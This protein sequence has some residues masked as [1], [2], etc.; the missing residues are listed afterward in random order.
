ML[1]LPSVTAAMRDSR[2]DQIF[3]VT[4][5]VIKGCQDIV[6]CSTCQV[7]CTDL[8][9]MMSVLQE[10]HACFD[11]IAKSDMDG[12]VKVSFGGYEVS[13]NNTEL[14]AML[15]MDLV[16]RADKLLTSIGSKG[17]SMVEKLS[18]PCCQAQANIAYLEATITHFRT[19][20]RCVTSYVTM[21][22][23]SP[24]CGV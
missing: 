21:A 22:E 19:I 9:L 11:Y 8:L 7:T 12:A 20:L 23:S 16:Q 4:G 18:E 3:K 1:L 2:L 15:V 6:D 14:R 5:E 24:V 13:S 10:T 17:Q